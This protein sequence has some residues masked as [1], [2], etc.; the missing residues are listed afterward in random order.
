MDRHKEISEKTREDMARMIRQS[1][2]AISA[3][4]EII[5]RVATDKA[6]AAADGAGDKPGPDDSTR[7]ETG[8]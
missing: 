1:D 4:K 8:T 6:T 7:T 3:S 2:A 5:N